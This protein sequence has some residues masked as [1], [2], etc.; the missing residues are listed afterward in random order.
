MRRPF[1]PVRTVIDPAG[2]EWEL[3]ISRIVMPDW[4]E[5]GYNAVV[6]APGEMV[7]AGPAIGLMLLDVPFALVGFVWSSVIVPALRLVLLTP[8]AVI[9]G[10]RSHAASILAICWSYS[11]GGSETRTW[12][13][14]IDQADSVLNEV[15]R[16]LEEGKTVQ[17]QGAVYSGSRGD[18]R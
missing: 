2:D 3:Y 7:P 5:G 15:A 17:P 10:R 16:G 13:T 4:R 12:T 14:T 9:K 11:G 18:G 6:D 1:R 8:F